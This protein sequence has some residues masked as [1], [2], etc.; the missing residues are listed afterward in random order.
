MNKVEY[1]MKYKFAL[2]FI[3][4]I[5]AFFLASQFIIHNWITL[6]Y[7]WQE[8]DLFHHLDPDPGVIQHRLPQRFEHQ[9]TF[10]EREKW[11]LNDESEQRMTKLDGIAN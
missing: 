7:I 10:E 11:K 6:V 3:S 8:I 2:S 1:R 4:V 5:S 9:M